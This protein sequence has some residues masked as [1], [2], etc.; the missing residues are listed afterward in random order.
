MPRRLL[1]LMVTSVLALAGCGLVWEPPPRT[2]MSDLTAQQVLNAG[3]RRLKDVESVSVKGSFREANRTLSVDMK[4]A[5]NSSSSTI[6]F[7]GLRF[8]V[9][10]AGGHTYIK[11]NTAAYRTIPDMTEPQLTKFIGAIGD[12]WIDSGDDATLGTIAE[13]GLRGEFFDDFATPTG[14]LTKGEEKKVEGV[15]CIAVSDKET[16]T[17]VDKRDGT[18]ILQ[19]GRGTSKGELVF[20]YKPVAEFRRPPAADVVTRAEFMS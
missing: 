2:A 11:A 17:Y 8:E 9:L 15:A 1:V 12:R 19:A 16:T 18:P 4:F 6:A 14:T 20:S 7:H 10:S 3:E 5:P 13:F